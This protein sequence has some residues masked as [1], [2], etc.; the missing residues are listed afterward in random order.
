MLLT[1]KTSIYFIPVAI[2]ILVLVVMLN[3]QNGAGEGEVEVHQPGKTSPVVQPNGG[4]EPAANTNGGQQAG[5]QSGNKELT[6][7]EQSLKN[8]QSLMDDEEKHEDA[9]K[10]ALTLAETGDAEQKVAA[11]ETF[12]WIGGHEAKMALTKLVPIGGLVTENAI[13]A[14]QHL[15][16]EDAQDSSIP[17]DAEAFSAAVL[18]LTGADRDSLFIVLG[19]YPVETQAPV[20]IS[21]MDTKDESLRELVFETFSSM[22]EGEEINS[23]V[24]A[25]KWVEKFKAENKTE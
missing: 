16:L 5:I 11:I 24:E 17:F 10:L 9:M 3:R 14:L 4:E 21:L 7:K 19:G 8:L 18:Q 2:I 12:N 1:R 22:A 13:S 23:K 6:A 25:E 20:L 15:F